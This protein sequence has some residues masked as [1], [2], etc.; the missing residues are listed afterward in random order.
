MPR[1]SCRCGES[2]RLH[3]V[4]CPHGYYLRSEQEIDKFLADAEQAARKGDQSDDL[5]SRL[6]ELWVKPLGKPA[7]HLYQCPNCGR[8]A[9]FAHPSK[10][11]VAQ[12]YLPEMPNIGP[13]SLDTLW[14]EQ[15][16]EDSEQA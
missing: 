9:V 11:T 16:D 12:W 6:F 14:R 10:R 1:L 7:P 4:P 13:T 3:D 8:L 15:P 5:E 2:I